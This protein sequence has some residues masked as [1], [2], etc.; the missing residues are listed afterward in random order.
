MALL[1]WHHTCI[2]LDKLHSSRVYMLT[3]LIV[4]IA[5]MSLNWQFQCFCNSFYVQNIMQLEKMKW[6]QKEIRNW[7]RYYGF[8]F[9]QYFWSDYFKWMPLVAGLVSASMV[10]LVVLT[11]VPFC[12]VGAFRHVITENFISTHLDS[13]VFIALYN[14]HLGSISVLFT[15]PFDMTI[16]VSIWV[17][18]GNNFEKGRF[19]WPIWSLV[20]EW[21]SRDIR[22]SLVSSMERNVC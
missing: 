15:L 12:L 17:L 6:W 4:K 3:M 11:F 20:T 18:L 22:G 13:L 16:F 2:W 1:F 19:W 7:L 8:K 5:T 10:G 21:I 14:Y 9:C